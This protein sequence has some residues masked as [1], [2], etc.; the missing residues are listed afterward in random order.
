MTSVVPEVRMT[1]AAAVARRIRP[2]HVTGRPH[3]TRAPES[4]VARRAVTH[5]KA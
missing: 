5:I 1:S 2:V 4:Q 3:R